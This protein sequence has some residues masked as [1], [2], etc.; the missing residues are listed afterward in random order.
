MAWRCVDEIIILES[1]FVSPQ[2]LAAVYWGMY[3]V[4]GFD[5]CVNEVSLKALDVIFKDCVGKRQLLVQSRYS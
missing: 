1:T 5:C 2:M 4:S 3:A